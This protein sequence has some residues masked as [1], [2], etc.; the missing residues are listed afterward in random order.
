M[1]NLVGR[2]H[3][4]LPALYTERARRVGDGRGAVAGQ[5]L[6]RKPVLPEPC[7]QLDCVTAQPLADREDVALRTMDEGNRRRLGVGV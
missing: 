4:R 1:R 6:D 2:R 5:N 7:D 3:C